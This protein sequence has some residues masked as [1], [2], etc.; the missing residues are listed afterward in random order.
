MKTCF[1]CGQEKPLEMF[2]AALCMA[3][4]H[5]GKCKECTKAEANERYRRKIKTPEWKL[6][7][8]R[9]N[10][11]KMRWLRENNSAPAVPQ[12]TRRTVV[13]LWRHNHPHKWL[14]HKSVQIALKNGWLIRKNC[15]QCGNVKTQAH[16]DDYSKLL[17][18]RWLCASCHAAHHVSMREAELL[19]QTG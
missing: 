7:E 11:L 19:K 10:R 18:V 16:H 12:E 8:R 2:Y 17:E 6:Q 9:R 5:S 14:A 3:D 4:G 13:K 1:K 15:E